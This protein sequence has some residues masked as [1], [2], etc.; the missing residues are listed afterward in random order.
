MKK[1]TVSV[2]GIGRVGLP[3]ALFIAS[4]GYK[5]FGIGRNQ[6]KIEKAATITIKKTA[7]LLSL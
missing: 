1:K 3:F 4:N 2:I 7:I 5:V 6:T